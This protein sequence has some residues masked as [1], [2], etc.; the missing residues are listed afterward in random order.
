MEASRLVLSSLLWSACGKRWATAE[1][2]ANGLTLE[3]RIWGEFLLKPWDFW[4][5]SK[6]PFVEGIRETAMHII[7][8]ISAFKNF[9]LAIL[10]F[11]AGVRG[12][13]FWP[14][15]GGGG[16]QVTLRFL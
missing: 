10:I 9:R 12:G 15:F 16:V 6:G 13:F 4:R 8:L 5:E 2:G 14:F 3:V 11:L 1:G 7:F